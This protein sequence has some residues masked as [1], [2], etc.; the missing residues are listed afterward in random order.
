VATP[1]FHNR[2]F[3]DTGFEV[4]SG[5]Q[6]IFNHGSSEE[7]YA[8]SPEPHKDK[9]LKPI[10]NQ[11]S[12][13]E[14][15]GDDDS[16]RSDQQEAPKAHGILLPLDPEYQTIKLKV[17]TAPDG[18]PES[19]CTREL[20]LLVDPASVG[21]RVFSNAIESLGLQHAPAFLN[22]QGQ[23]SLATCSRVRGVALWG[24]VV[25]AYVEVGKHWTPQKIALQAIGQGN[26]G[27]PSSTSSS[28]DFSQ[29]SFGDRPLDWPSA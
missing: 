6:S 23:A 14:S 21:I 25:Q 27:H 9:P 26:L 11:A 29:K 4:Y 1:S 8:C 17:C 13:E 16:E 12:L 19:R 18:K 22:G 5:D 24:P 7:P 10:Y 28:A 2:N 15:M 20:R 3:L